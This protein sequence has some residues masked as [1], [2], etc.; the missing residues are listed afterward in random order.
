MAIS[1]IDTNIESKL[2]VSDIAL[3]LNVTRNYLSK[4]FKNDT[5][6]T[7]QQYIINSKLNQAKKLLETTNLTVTEISKKLYFSNQ[8]HF[9]NT[10]KKNFE[11]TPVQYRIKHQKIK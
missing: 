11:M 10:F 5:G 1:Y 6:I 8:S 4:C 2:Q 3:K 7:I 9:Q